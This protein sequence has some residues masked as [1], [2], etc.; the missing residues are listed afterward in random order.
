MDGQVERTLTPPPGGLDLGLDQTVCAADRQGCPLA[1]RARDRLGSEA[2]H[3][4]GLQGPQGRRR[5]GNYPVTLASGVVAAR[6]P[7]HRPGDGSSG[8][9]FMIVSEADAKSFLRSP[10]ISLYGQGA[11][12]RED[13][14]RT[15]AVRSDRLRSRLPTSP[16]WRRPCGADMRRRQATTSS[17]SRRT[18]RS[19]GRLDMED[20]LPHAAGMPGD[21]RSGRGP[22]AAAPA[23]VRD[24]ADPRGAT[25]GIRAPQPPIPP[26]DAT[27]VGSPPT[28]PPPTAESPPTGA[29]PTVGSSPAGDPPAAERPSIIDP[30]ERVVVGHPVRHLRAAEPQPPA[31]DPEHEVRPVSP[32]RPQITPGPAPP[33]PRAGNPSSARSS[34]S[35]ASPNSS[36]CL[37]GSNGSM[38]CHGPGSKYPTAA[39]SLR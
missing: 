5:T 27:T 21:G 13:V 18:P 6:F 35:T 3:H 23:F 24:E 19:R 30:D 32:Q 28:R 11:G 12:A 9:T 7:C 34:S 26:Q 16:A 22:V 29:P 31:E 10:G 36:A 17:S 1:S 14:R 39:R 33:T 15:S 20:D 2:D 25:I 37:N 4:L 8:P 38:P